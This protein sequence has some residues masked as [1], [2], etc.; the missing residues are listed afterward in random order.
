MRASA[1]EKKIIASMTDCG[2]VVTSFPESCG[3][4]SGE[5]RVSVPGPEVAEA[6]VTWIVSC[7]PES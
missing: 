2:R 1:V 3:F 5:A 6:A 4:T 7:A